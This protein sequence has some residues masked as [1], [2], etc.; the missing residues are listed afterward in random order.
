MCGRFTLTRFPDEWTELLD[1]PDFETPDARYNVAPGQHIL[2]IIRDPEHKNPLPQM[3]HWGLLP[4]WAKD[5]KSAQRPINARC[6]TAATKPFF[7]SAMRH[8][9]CLVPA[10]GFFEWAG[11]GAKKR[12]YYF[13]MRDKAPFALGGIWD[14]WHGKNDELV[15]SCAILTTEPNSLLKSYHHRMPVILNSEHFKL[16]L[17]PDVQTSKDVEHLMKPYDPKVM[18]A[19]A[20]STYVNSPRND[21]EQCLFPEMGK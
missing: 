20:V 21:D 14:R 8:H 1:L 3:L 16:W 13:R 15:D 9:R 12:P 19:I 2:T 17:D 10:D 11:K 18:E 4:H 5:S 6:E 7:R